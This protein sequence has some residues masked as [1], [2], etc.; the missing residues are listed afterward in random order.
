MRTL[1]TAGKDTELITL[2]TADLEA[3]ES[4]GFVADGEALVVILSGALEVEVDGARLG[5]AGGRASVFDGGG[6]A[7]YLPPGATVKLTEAD[8][9]GAAIAVEYAWRRVQCDAVRAQFRTRA[10]IGGGVRDGDESVQWDR[11]GSDSQQLLVLERY[12]D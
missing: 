8:A 10:G 1:I 5:R 6:D 7:V 4:L 3:G 12:S 9:V 2:E 11:G